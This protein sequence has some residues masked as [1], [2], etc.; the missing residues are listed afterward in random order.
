MTEWE[1][2]A[3]QGSKLD[4][5]PKCG[6]EGVLSYDFKKLGKHSFRFCPTCRAIFVDGQKAADVVVST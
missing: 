5:C 3:R 1:E 2:G 6:L 4:L